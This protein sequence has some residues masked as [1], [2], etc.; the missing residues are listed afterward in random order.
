[1][2]MHVYIYMILFL[3]LAFI[4]VCHYLGMVFLLDGYRFNLCST[5]PCDFLDDLL[6]R[7]GLFISQFKC[8]P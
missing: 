6:L 4:L 2:Y 3:L 7:G 1:M 8:S 5:L